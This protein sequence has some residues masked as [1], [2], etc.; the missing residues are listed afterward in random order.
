MDLI[1]SPIEGKSKGYRATVTVLSI[2][3]GVFVVSYLVAYLEGFQVWGINNAVPWGQVIT[4]DIYF[5]GLSAGAI[6]VSGLSYVL[7]REEYKSIGRIAIFLGLIL[8]CGAL[9]FV[10]IDLGRPEKFW[11]LFMFGYLNNMGSLFALNGIWYGGYVLLMVLYLWLA[12]ENKIRLAMIIGTVDILW[13]VA[14]HSFTGAIFGLIGSR[15]IFFSSLKPFEF[16]AAAVTSGTALLII[17]LIAAFKFSKR[18]LDQKIIFDLGRL[19]S[20]VLIVLLLMVFFDK[21]TH[22]YFPNREGTTF[23]LTGPYWWLFWVFQIGLG[24]ALPLF[25]LFLPKTKRS[26]KWIIIASASVVIGVLGERA[27]LVIPGT[28]QVQQV[29]PGKIEGVW[30]AAGSFPITFWETALTVGAVSL[31]ALIF[32][33]GL[34]YLPLLPVNNKVSGQAD[35]KPAAQDNSTTLEETR[36]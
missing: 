11:R 18:R 26:I 21:L 36:I 7:K 13:A 30:G 10:L 8:F 25:L 31:I 16:I 17:V 27:A 12:M 3:V 34:K 9:I 14:V 19:L 33:L 4:L 24:I 22:S 35:E 23:L 2:L 6:V 28:A 20:W 1:Y 29:Y 5:I 15:E 32:M